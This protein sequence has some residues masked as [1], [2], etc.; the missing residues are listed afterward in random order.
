MALINHPSWPSG[1]K[2]RVAVTVSVVLTVVVLVLYF[3]LT[4]DA[5][6]GWPVLLLG[7]VVSQAAYALLLTGSAG[8]VEACYGLVD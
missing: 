6:P 4:G 1:S 2:R 8:R 5:V 7:V 3:V